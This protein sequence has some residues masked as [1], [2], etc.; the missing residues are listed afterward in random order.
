ML[1]TKS[2]TISYQKALD[3]IDKVPN[4]SEK[5]ACD[6]DYDTETF[7]EHASIFVYH[8]YLGQFLKSQ[9]EKSIKTS[10]LSM[11]RNNTISALDFI[12]ET[13]A[14]IDKLTPNAD[15]YWQYVSDALPN[16]EFQTIFLDKTINIKFSFFKNMRDSQLNS[17]KTKFAPNIKANMLI[18]A[19]TKNPAKNWLYVY[20]QN[21]KQFVLLK[22]ADLKQ[23]KEDDDF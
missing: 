19:A 14:T 22:S 4:P 9:K 18:Q 8:V 20:D 13:S 15:N 2:K 6:S 17:I 1:L 5:Y 11:L 16:H 21:T 3:K 7:W 10:K 23:K 12:H